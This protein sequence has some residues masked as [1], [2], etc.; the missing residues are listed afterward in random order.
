MID[1]PTKNS[2]GKN[3]RFIFETAKVV[4]L[5]VM[6]QRQFPDQS[7]PGVGTVLELCCAVCSLLC[8]C[9]LRARPVPAYVEGECCVALN[10]PCPS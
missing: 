3:V 10:F 2:D 7:V 4:D 8:I 1:P 9:L 6:L 5:E